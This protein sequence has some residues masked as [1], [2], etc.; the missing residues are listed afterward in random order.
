MYLGI[1]RVKCRDSPEKIRGTKM[2]EGYHGAM[3]VKKQIIQ[4]IEASYY[5]IHFATILYFPYVKN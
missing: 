4:S 3:I 2:E 5:L 1:C